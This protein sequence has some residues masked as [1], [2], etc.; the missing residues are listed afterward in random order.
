[1]RLPAP[2]TAGAA[3]G[4][5]CINCCRSGHFARECTTPKKTAT[6]GHVT[7]LS[8]GPQKVAVVKTGRINYTTMEDIPE[9]EQVLVGTFSLNRHPTTVLFDSRASPDFI[10]KTCTQKHQLVIE[11]IITPYLIRTPGGNIASKQLVIATPLSL[12]WRLFRTNLIVLEGQGIDVILRM[13]WMKRYKTV[14]DIAARTVHL[15]SPTHGNIVLKPPSPIF[16][17][18]ALHHTA[19]LNLEGIPV[20]CEFPDVFPEDLPGIHP[21]QDVEFVIE[22]QPGTA[23]ISRRPYKMTPKELAKLKVQLNELLDKGYICPSSS[24]CGCPALFVKKK[25][26]S[27]RLCVDY[28]P[29]NAVTIKNKY[30][31]PRID[32][33]FDQLA[34]ASVFSMVDLCL[35]YH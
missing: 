23:P 15:E 29:L 16:I 13:G 24:P 6:Q 17:A 18:L 20:A 21:D 27:L 26:Q 28:R 22:L 35:G 7:P 1:M 9:G 33:L 32:I 31:L 34:G 25:D 11:H 4:H 12:A 14:L 3:S 8:R 2:P 30:P 5:T 19:A 10:S